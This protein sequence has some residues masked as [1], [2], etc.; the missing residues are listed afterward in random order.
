[1][2]IIYDDNMPAAVPAQAGER[3]EK[4]HLVPARGECRLR[5]DADGSLFIERA[6]SEV[7]LLDAFLYQ[8]VGPNEDNP[9]VEV[10]Y[11]PFDLCHP[12][13]CCQTWRDGHCFG[14]AVITINAVNGT[15]TYRVGRYVNFGKWQA[16]RAD[17]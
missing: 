2:R 4:R 17:R 6:D 7:W 9:W 15:V 16:T 5:R 10:S 3:L 8:L 13:Q 1:V 12:N 14:G 11:R